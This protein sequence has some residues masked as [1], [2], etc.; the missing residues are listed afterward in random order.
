MVALLELVLGLL[1]AALVLLELTGTTDFL[2]RRKLEEFVDRQEREGP[3][4][5]EEDEGDDDGPRF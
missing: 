1:L 2:G 3:S 5:R 4:E